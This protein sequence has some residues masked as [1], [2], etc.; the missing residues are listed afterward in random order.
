MIL[1]KEEETL[2]SSISALIAHTAHLEL[3]FC[4]RVDR[5][6]A[7]ARRTQ[8]NQTPVYVTTHAA[9]CKYEERK[10]KLFFAKKKTL[11]AELIRFAVPMWV[12]GNKYKK[13][14]VVKMKQIECC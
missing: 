5:L 7:H 4:A 11:E 10:C 13:M 9:I 14:S 3:Q 8:R 1:H 2:A 6:I 12:F